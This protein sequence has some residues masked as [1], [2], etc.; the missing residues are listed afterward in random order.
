MGFTFQPQ[1]QL[2]HRVLLLALL[3]VNGEVS[4]A[5]HEQP[6]AGRVSN[7][8]LFRSL[9]TSLTLQTLQRINVAPSTAVH[10]AVYPTD[11]AWIVEGGITD[12]VQARGLRVT[13]DDSAAYNVRFG[14]DEARVFYTNV[15]RDGFLG[16]KLVD[17]LV[18]LRLS[19]KVVS[20]HSHSEVATFTVQDS[21]AD[22]LPLSEVPS[23]EH[24]AVPLTRGSLP[25]EGFFSNLAEPLIVIGSIAIAVLLLFHVRS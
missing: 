22:T 16:E 11:V 9:A 2:F 14:V 6:L 21:L 4:F 3:V 10:I 20:R 8:D 1:V 18:R 15:R 17:R 13:D 24:P 23:V 5:Q 7:L 25:G 12:A 19:A